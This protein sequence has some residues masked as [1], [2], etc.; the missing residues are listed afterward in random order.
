MPVG[1]V[2]VFIRLPVLSLNQLHF[3]NS[4]AFNTSALTPQDSKL[5]IC[6]LPWFRP[7][8]EKHWFR[9]FQII[10]RS[11]RSCAAVCY[12]LTAYGAPPLVDICNQ[13][14]QC[15]HSNLTYLEAVS[16]ICDL[17]MHHAVMTSHVHDDND[18]NNNNLQL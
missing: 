10:H 1:S 3:V 14:I 11:Q 4:L 15:I 17:R 6:H 12:K 5:Q 8:V 18:D 2:R 16:P 7:V 9:P 13:L